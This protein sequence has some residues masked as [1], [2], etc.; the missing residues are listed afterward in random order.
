MVPP[1]KFDQP[2]LGIE[3]FEDVVEGLDEDTGFPAPEQLAT[4]DVAATQDLINTG[5]YL[6]EMEQTTGWA[7]LMAFVGEEVNSLLGQLKKE[8]DLNQIT[9][10]QA[11]IEALEL[12]PK[13]TEKLKTSAKAAQEV[14]NQYTL[15]ATLEG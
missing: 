5:C 4:D 2:D 14:L 13:I 8:R 9:R 11:L 1:N 15:S 3:T 7:L 10:L 12:L 6:Q